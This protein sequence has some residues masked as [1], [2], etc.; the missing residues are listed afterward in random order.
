MPPHVKA[1]ILVGGPSRGPRFRPLS[2]DIPK[3]LFPL[4]GKPLLQHH[5]DYLATVEGLST[6][7]LVGFF[8]QQVFSAFLAQ[9]RAE[10]PFQV[11]Y[12]RE[13]TS[14]GTAGGLFH[15]RDEI[16]AG[17]TD[18]FFVLNAD[19]SFPMSALSEMLA[20]HAQH[21]GLATVLGKRVGKDWVRNFGCLVVDPQ[22]KEVVLH[23][24]K[25]RNDSMVLSEVVSCGVYLLDAEKIFEEIAQ[26]KRS[27][28]EKKWQPWEDEEEE[29]EFALVK[30]S[31]MAQPLRLEQ[32]V[33]KCLA[34]N[35]KLFVWETKDVWR[36]LKTA[37]YPFLLLHCLLM[38]QPWK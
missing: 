4:A 38:R 31:D 10:Y 16:L 18:L 14:L 3:P 1:V 37:G 35:R 30:R 20:W 25:P 17:R 34:G 2:L 24:E 32:D 8:D 9:V 5:L 28:D 11:V 13:Y 26:I 22:S 23:I 29:G 33:L 21:P 12:L 15:F 7:Y 36:P 6:V 19:V 27:K